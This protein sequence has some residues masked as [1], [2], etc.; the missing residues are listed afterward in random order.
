MTTLVPRRL[1]FPKR[2]RNWFERLSV[3]AMKR[4]K[5]ANVRWLIFR[6]SSARSSDNE[7]RSLEEGMS[8]IVRSILPVLDHFDL[9]LDP[10]KKSM[11]VDQLIGGVKIVRDELDKTLQVHGVE[12]IEPA[13]GDEFDPQRHEAMMHEPSAS[14]EPG[15]VVKVYQPGYVMGERVLRPAKVAVASPTSD[16]GASDQNDE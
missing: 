1:N 3:S 12:R 8:R 10:G 11:T 13:I 4:L 7:R 16:K 14:V 6:T 15:H 5:A 2:R 9:A